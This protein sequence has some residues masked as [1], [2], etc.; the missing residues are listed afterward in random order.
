MSVSFNF[1]WDGEVM[2]PLGRAKEEC[3]KLKKNNV[4]RFKR[5]EVRSG[6]HHRFYFAAI[7]EAWENLGPEDAKRFPSPEHLRHYALIK[8]GYAKQRQFALGSKVDAQRLAVFQK[9]REPYAVVVVKGEVVTIYEAMSQALENMEPTTFK[10]SSDAVLEY[11]AALIGVSVE[12]LSK[13]AGN[14]A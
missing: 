3:A 8:A 9:T 1:K 2:I 11:C 13:N 6:P 12:D 4:Y 7:N 10:A 14:H 5:Q